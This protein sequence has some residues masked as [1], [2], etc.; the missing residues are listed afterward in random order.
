[1]AKSVI[2]EYLET[3][4]IAGILA[5]IIITLFVQ[6]FTIPTGSML[7]TLQIGDYVLVNKFLYGIKIPFTTR[8]ILPIRQPRR[9]DII[10][11]RAPLEPR[12]LIKRIIGL[13]GEEI[14][15]RD[16]KVY[17]DGVVLKDEPY[18]KEE[19]KEDFG[20]VRVPPASYFVMGDNRNNSA[21]SRWGWFVP[22]SNIRGKAMIVYFSWDNQRHRPRFSRIGRILR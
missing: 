5:L 22:K 13:P 9:G 8:R 1:M 11:F 21:D 14:E 6:A 15:V 19:P 18:I 20:P 10:V 3:L 7:D 4:I 12:D 16:G 17:I 2:R